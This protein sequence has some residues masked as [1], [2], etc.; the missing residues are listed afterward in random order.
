[1]LW[2]WTEIF[3]LWE[4]F[5]FPK[6]N[7]ELWKDPVNPI[8]LSACLNMAVGPCARAMLS[9]E[10]FDWLLWM[11]PIEGCWALTGCP[12]TLQTSMPGSL[13]SVIS[14]LL[15]S[16]GPTHPPLLS[17]SGSIQLAQHPHIWPGPWSLITTHTYHTH[18]YSMC[19]VWPVVGLPCA[20]VKASGLSRT[21]IRLSHSP[22]PNGRPLAA[23]YLNVQRNIY[24]SLWILSPG[25][26]ALPSA[27]LLHAWLP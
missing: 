13:V 5:E 14:P 7:K 8:K 16:S 12:P 3:C 23:A 9:Y 1:M 10:T 4:D 25:L 20:F 6:L 26:T 15:F 27:H 18:R 24:F 2:V 11:R 17:G 21:H 19:S 22:V